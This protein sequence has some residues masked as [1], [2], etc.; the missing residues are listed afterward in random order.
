MVTLAPKYYSDYY[1]IKCILLQ[2]AVLLLCT[3]AVNNTSY[4]IHCYLHLSVER[5][6]V[7]TF[8]GRVAYHKTTLF[9]FLFEEGF[10]SLSRHV[11]NIPPVN[12]A[13]L[14]IHPTGKQNSL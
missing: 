12:P 1:Q 3:L 5:K 7:E 10:C 4:L 6:G 2:C 14:V 8:G 13:L 9:I 11:T